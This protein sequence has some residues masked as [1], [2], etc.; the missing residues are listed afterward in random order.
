MSTVATPAKRRYRSPTRTARAEI[1]L[2]EF[3]TEELHKELEHRGES[4]G[5]QDDA[6]SSSN[7]LCLSPELLNRLCTLLVCG[8]HSTAVAEL[9]AEVDPMVEHR[10]SRAAAGSRT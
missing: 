2:D 8:Q 3:E 6:V 7:G 10:F 9:L 1:C 4:A 5:Q